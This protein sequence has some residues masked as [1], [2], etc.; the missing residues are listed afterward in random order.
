MTCCEPS[1]PPSG[2][3]YRKHLRDKT[4]ACQQSRYDM[5]A[6]RRALPPRPSRSEQARASRAADA[7]SPRSVVDPDDWAHQSSDVHEEL[8]ERAAAVQ[9]LE[10]SFT[11]AEAEWH[12]RQMATS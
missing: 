9:W 4:E 8:R 6:Y 5:A 2:R 1:I 12:Q 7:P 10:D 11:A 3:T